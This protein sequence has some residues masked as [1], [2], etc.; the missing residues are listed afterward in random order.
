MAGVSD[1]AVD[2][3]ETMNGPGILK[4]IDQIEKLDRVA[5]RTFGLDEIRPCGIQ[6]NILSGNFDAGPV[7]DVQTRDEAE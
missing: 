4:S 6:V 7:I 3:I 5:R 1:R 2:H